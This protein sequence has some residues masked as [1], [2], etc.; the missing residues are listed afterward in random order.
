MNL[1]IN[2]AVAAAYTADHRCVRETD[3]LINERTKIRNISVFLLYFF[4]NMFDNNLTF[5]LYHLPNIVYFPIFYA[6]SQVT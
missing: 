2:L 4:Y 1:K 5:F 6:F 3:R